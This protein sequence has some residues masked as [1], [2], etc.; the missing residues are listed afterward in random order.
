MK[1]T[2]KIIVLSLLSLFSSLS[3]S[4]CGSD[5]KKVEIKDFRLQVKS[6]DPDVHQ[7]FYQLIQ[8]YNER[9]GITALSYVSNPDEAN[10]TIELIKGLRLQDKKVGW[11]QWVKE[12]ETSG[13]NMFAVNSKPVKTI[14]YTMKVEFDEDYMTSRLALSDED[15][16]D[17]VFK[18]FA[19]EV[20]HGFLLEH[21]PD[22]SNVMYFDVSGK[23]EYESYFLNVQNFFAN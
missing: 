11:G 13:V 22:P 8:D 12:T 4:S 9:A 6:G 17:E 21:H 10:S 7:F 23:K 3:L 18:L 16:K 19:H 15:E 14:T 5:Y 20:G 1:K 2:S